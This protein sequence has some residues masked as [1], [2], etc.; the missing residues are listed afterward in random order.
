MTGFSGV[1]SVADAGADTGADGEE[2]TLHSGGRDM[3]EHSLTL[4]A[5]LLMWGFPLALVVFVIAESV[6]DRLSSKDHTP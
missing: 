1:M 5:H 4:G 2:G 6:H 3:E